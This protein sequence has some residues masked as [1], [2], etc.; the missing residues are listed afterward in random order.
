MFK[1]EYPRRGWILKLLI[2]VVVL[3]LVALILYYLFLY[4]RKCSD[5]ACFNKNLV[6]CRRAV[7]I[8]DAEEATWLYAV[9]K[10]IKDGCEVKIQLR[11]IKQGPVDIGKTEGKSMK[12]Y[13]P[14]GVMT[15]PGQDLTKCTG[16]LKE[17][18]QDLIIKKMH[19]YILQNLGEINEELT[20]PI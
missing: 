3:L 6:E 11:T 16:P 20:K 13:S 12:C 9:R 7:W 17:A 4:S 1:E 19:A 8:N 14:L 2:C 10:K 15:S 18:F 5:E